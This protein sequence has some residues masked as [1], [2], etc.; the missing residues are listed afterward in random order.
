MSDA[1]KGEE[2]EVEVRGLTLRGVRWGSGEDPP[3]LALHGW[4]DNCAGFEAVGRGL[5][6]LQVVAL[7]LAGHGRSDW[8]SRDGAYHF[9]DY[10][11]DVME[12][13]RVLGWEE[14]GLLGHSM[15]GAVSSLVGAVQPEGLKR[16]VLI[17][18]IGPRSTPAM[19]SPQVLR[20]ALEE[21]RGLSAKRGVS[22][23]SV[24]G[25]AERLAA[26]RGD[27]SAEKL[28]GMAARASEPDGE[29]G[30]RFCFDPRL[31]GTSRVRF[32]EEQVR[33][34]LGALEVP[35]LLVRP[36]QGWPVSEDQVKG[37]ID[38]IRDLK[39]VEIEG[40]HHVHV[41]DPERVLEVIGPFLNELKEA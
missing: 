32:V 23:E 39:L 37:R 15:G 17:D 19:A 33:A 22:S 21:E 36:R 6:G 9:V 26:A 25:I 41:S 24:R 4:L 5:E 2:V 7:D 14:Y 13:L 8:R 35:V 20:Q 1:R 11:A 27:V 31:Q 38:R 18:A 3:V 12:A 10:V 16:V 30:V 34:Y 40:G 28:M 29:G